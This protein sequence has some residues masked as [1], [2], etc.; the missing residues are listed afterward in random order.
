[1]LFLGLSPATGIFCLFVYSLMPI[2]RST[3]TALTSPS[4]RR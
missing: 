1:M 4:T 3:Y 2:I